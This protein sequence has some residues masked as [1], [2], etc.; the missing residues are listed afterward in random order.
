MARYI[1]LDRAS[2]DSEDAAERLPI[3]D[4]VVLEAESPPE[5]GMVF[6]ER[7]Y[8]LPPIPGKLQALASLPKEADPND[9]RPIAIKEECGLYDCGRRFIFGSNSRIG[10][11]DTGLDATHP[12]IAPCFEAFKDFIDVDQSPKDP[13]GH[14]TG[15]VGVACGAGVGV[16]KFMGVASG[17]KALMA[18]VIDA[19]G[20]AGEVDIIKGLQWLESQGVDIINMS[21]G[22][23]NDAYGPLEMAMEKAKATI[24]VAAGNDGP[25]KHVMAPANVPTAVVVAACDQYGNHSI[26][27]SL[28]PTRSK[29]ELSI[30]KPDLMAWGENVP[31]P[32]AKGTSMGTVIDDNYVMADGTSFAAPFVSGCFALYK[33]VK[34]TL[35]NA[36]L[37]ATATA[38]ASYE[39]SMPD[40]REGYGRIDA[41]AM[42]D[43]EV[44]GSTNTRPPKHPSGCVLGFIGMLAEGIRKL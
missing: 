18:R 31:M 23:K 16:H 12:D 9:G 32:R 20:W 25:K 13:I 26:F 37:A 22:F 36:F 44:S 11:L 29:G 41:K 43:F 34:G 17:A 1:V 24:V 5:G 33:G 38:K 42:I 15:V 27:S 30:P 14:G 6:E 2:L 4:A 10:F 35:G 39:Q 3:I 40:P 7:R 21:L 8:F 19:D 28:G